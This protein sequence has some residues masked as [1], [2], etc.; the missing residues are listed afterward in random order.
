MTEAPTITLATGEAVANTDPAW[1]DECFKRWERVLQCRGQ[2]MG[3]VR[4]MLDNVERSEGNEARRRL[5][6]ALREDF[7][8]RRGNVLERQR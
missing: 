4:T 5:E 6:A 8:A 1:R 7:E 3:F 2:K